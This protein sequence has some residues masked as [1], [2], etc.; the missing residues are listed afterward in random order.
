MVP[1]TIPTRVGR[2]VQV[3]ARGRAGRTIPT[4]VG[5]TTY[6][7]YL[8]YTN[9]D[10]PHA[11]GENAMMWWKVRMLI[12]PSPRV[13]GEHQRGDRRPGRARTI[14]TRVGRTGQIAINAWI[15]SDHPH[16]C[17]ENGNSS[18]RA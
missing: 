12:G 8:S 7:P 9:A 13:W 2:T 3:V 16:A 5:R 17:G 10:H 11:C 15:N 18:K 6:W 1:R 14:P 4:R